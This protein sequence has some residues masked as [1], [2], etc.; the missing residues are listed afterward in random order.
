MVSASA[1]QS[2]LC[3]NDTPVLLT[4]SPLGGTFSGNGIVGNTFDPMLS[5]A[6]IH[7][8]TYQY[9]DINSCLGTASLDVIVNP[10]P[11]LTLLPVSNL[12]VNSGIYS[13]NNG[14]PSGG[15][16]LIDGVLATEINTNVLSTGVHNLT[17]NY[18]PANGCGNTISTQFTINALPVVS[19]PIF[20]DICE[21]ATPI[22][23]SGGLPVGGD[24][25]GA[26]VLGGVFYPNLANP[27]NAIT[28]V[29]TDVNGCSASISQ[30]ITVLTPQPIN[31]APISFVS[32]IAGT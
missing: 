26:G 23:L 17:Y 15:S 29:Y 3:L 16:Y 30:T 14:F 11:Q 25:I 1:A 8:I 18:S 32:N 12:C 9:T 27:V 7:T 20:A 10:L 22:V 21:T 5:G 31:F 4:G 2:L 19:L 24:Y 6:G 28:Y 13:L